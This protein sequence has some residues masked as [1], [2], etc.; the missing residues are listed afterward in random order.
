MCGAKTV[1]GGA[2]LRSCCGGVKKVD[3]LTVGAGNCCGNPL[4]TVWAEVAVLTQPVVI[5]EKGNVVVQDWTNPGMR[6]AAAVT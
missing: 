2:L 5:D 4:D 3:G 1:I 6:P